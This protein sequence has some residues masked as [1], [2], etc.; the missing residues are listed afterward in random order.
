VTERMSLSDFREL[1]G[2]GERTSLDKK[3]SRKI[4]VSAKIPKKSQK[5][6]KRASK[7]NAKKTVISG[8][9]F[10]SK[11]EAERYMFLSELLRKNKI[12]DLILQEKF[13]IIIDGIFICSYVT[14][15][16]YKN[17][18]TGVRITEDVKGMKT[19][20]YR[21]KKKLIKAVFGINIHEVNKD[22]LSEL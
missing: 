8:I 2:R 11:V 15:F 1:V 9:V 13:D 3:V 21:L 10:D 20:V 7:Y 22:N 18:A 14:D 17:K 12:S 19:P 16:S 6:E 4:S 5:N